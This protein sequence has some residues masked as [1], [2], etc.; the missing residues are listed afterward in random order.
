M[1]K[2]PLSHWRLHNLRG[3]SHLIAMFA[4]VN[5]QIN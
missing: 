5:L 2:I 4:V 1:G 3:L